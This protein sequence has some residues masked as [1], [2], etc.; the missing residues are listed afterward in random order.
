MQ[1]EL[2]S[3]VSPDVK[4]QKPLT[5][6]DMFGLT[7]QGWLLECRK[8][9]KLLLRH[10]DS[11]T[12]EDILVLVPRPEFIHRNSTGSIF[13]GQFKQVGWTQSKRPQSKGRYI[14]QWR[15]K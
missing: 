3:K 9:A 10:M 7:R 12:V 4:V 11:I 5:V 6:Q 15:L 2:F 8:T 14:M 13:D 1:R